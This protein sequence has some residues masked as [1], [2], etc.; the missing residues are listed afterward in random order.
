MK[1]EIIIATHKQKTILNNF[2][3]RPIQVG[4]A[5]NQ[6]TI[7]DTYYLDNQG[8]NISSKNPNFNELT[9]LYWYWK[10]KKNADYVGLAHYRR[11]L[12]IFYEK[13]IFKKEKKNVLKNVKSNYSSLLKMHNEEKARKKLISLF[14]NYDLILPNPGYC[15]ANGKDCTISEDYKL[16][17]IASDWDT[18]IDILIS[19][20]PEYKNSVEKYLN[21]SNKFYIGNMFISSYK[22]FNDYCNWLFDILFEV[23]KHI[24]ISEDPYQG[25]VFGFLSE[26]LFTLYVQHHNFKTKEFPIL[27]IED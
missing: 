9:A 2:I 17:H 10:N 18:T 11:Y 23:E 21:Q 7:N 4:R 8:E 1:F 3:F 27:F 26:R 5:V 22:W 24:L 14:K 25:R 16:H 19:K 20:Y 12:D 6:Y 13:G 15:N